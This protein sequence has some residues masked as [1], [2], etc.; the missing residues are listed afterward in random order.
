MWY[1]RVFEKDKGF[2]KKGKV[3]LLY[4]PRRVGKT[5]LI[6]KLISDFKGQVFIGSGDD[7]RIRKILS[8]ED[9][10]LILNAF[11]GYDIIFIDEAQRIEKV[12]WGL[13]ILIDNLPDKIIIASGSSS[14]QLSAQVGEPLTGRDFTYLLFPVSLYELNSQLGGMKTIQNLENYLI[15][16]MYPEI[17]TSSN[18]NEKTQYLNSLRNSYLFKDILELENIK[19]SDKL[20]DILKLLAFQIGNEVSLSELG[21]KVGLAKQT[22]ER[23]L[24]LLEKSFVIKRIGGFSKNLR[25]EVVKSSRYYFYDNGIRNSIINNYN[26]LDQRNDI[27]MLWENFMVLERIKVQQY[28]S[29]FANYY[30][31]RTY[32]Q[33][34]VDLVEER[35]GKLY[36]FEFKWNPAKAKVQHEWLKTYTNASFEIVNRDN[37]LGFV[38]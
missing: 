32:D 25:K 1:K 22:V 2:F 7:I 14:F 21:K 30:F 34:E 4:G 33:K 26:T 3:N 11:S 20:F 17:L 6:E 27:G 16:G 19:N 13:K 12:G 31:W 5:S 36:G 18:N 38:V 35:D 37:F 23:Y 24:D 28:K 9:K 10:T 8:S 15:Y 29:I